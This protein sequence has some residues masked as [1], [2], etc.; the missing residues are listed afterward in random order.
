MAAATPE[1]AAPK[2]ITAPASVAPARGDNLLVNLL[3]NIVVPTLIL[4]QLSGEH[5]LGPT[6]AVVA[7]LVFPLGYGLRDALV[8][9]KFNLFSALGVLSVALTGGISLLGLDPRY[10]AIKEAAVPGII[11][12]ITLASLRTRY[13]LVRSLLFNPAV[14]DVDRVEAAL[15]ERASGRVFERCLV[16]ASWIIAGSFFLSSLLNYVLAV[17]LVTSQPGTEEYNQQLGTMTALSYPV[18]ALPATLVMM[19]GLFYLLR[20]ITRLTGLPVEA[21]LRHSRQD[22]P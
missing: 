6:W 22:A 21:I 20:S 15:A 17:V 5:R 10:L 2:P 1:P 4:T 3:F 7:A 8:R 12:L 11:G 18:I 14:V 13:P 9:K 19:G 16:N